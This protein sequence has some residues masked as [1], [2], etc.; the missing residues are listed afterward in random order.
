[1]AMVLGGALVGGSVATG[2][3]KFTVGPDGVGIG[4]G[5]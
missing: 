5:G 4:K 3:F 1:M 2:L